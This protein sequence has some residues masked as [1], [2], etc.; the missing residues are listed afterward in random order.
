[1]SIEDAEAINEGVSMIPLSYKESD[2]LRAANIYQKFDKKGNLFENRLYVQTS[3][4]QAK[5]EKEQIKYEK[6]MEQ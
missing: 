3:I 5:L 1:M 2:L 4:N 6:K